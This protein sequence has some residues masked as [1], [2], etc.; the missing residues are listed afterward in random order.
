[1]EMID[2]DYI[3]IYTNKG[4]FVIKI[5]LR[6]LVLRMSDPLETSHMTID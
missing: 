2:N 3:S 5:W 4:T 6:D 1:M